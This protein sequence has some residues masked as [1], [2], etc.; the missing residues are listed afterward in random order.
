MDKNKTG[1]ESRLDEDL[2]LEDESA[3]Q[4]TGGF[5][6]EARRHRELHKRNV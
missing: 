6:T 5:R 3:E 2:P 4:V 1:D